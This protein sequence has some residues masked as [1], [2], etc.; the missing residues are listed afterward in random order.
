MQRSPLSAQGQSAQSDST[1]AKAADELALDAPVANLDDA[2]RQLLEDDRLQ[3]EFGTFEAPELE[4]PT[5]IE[6]LWRFF[7]SIAPFLGYVFWAGVA[8]GVLMILYLIV[9]ELLRRLPRRTRAVA[10]PAPSPKPEYRPAQTRAQA[11]LSEA[12]RLAAEGRFSEAVRVLLHRSIED[13]ERVFALPIAPG[14]TAREIGSI[15]PLSPNG[16]TVFAGIARAVETS[17]FGGQ[18]LSREDFARCREA[19]ASFALNGARS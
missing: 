16:R 12:D 4:R 3:F 9:S 13:I 17:L 18:P 5:W 8:I 14:L 7:E 6:P 19:Y 15:E 2:H 1:P 10:Q 11:L